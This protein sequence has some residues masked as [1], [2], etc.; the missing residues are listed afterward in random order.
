MPTLV[1]GFLSLS[2]VCAVA[3]S[4]CQTL[5]VEKVDETLTIFWK[6]KTVVPKEGRLIFEGGVKA[7]YGPTVLFADR[8]EIATNKTEK[9]GL[10]Q[11]NVRIEDPDAEAKMDSFSFDWG[12]QI[13]N[14]SNVTFSTAGLFLN[15][16]RAEITAVEWVFTGVKAS[17]D[18]SAHPVFS[19]KS[20]R[21]TYRPGHSGTA[22]RAS[23]S[24]FGKDWVTLPSY[25]FGQKEEG[26]I[27]RFPSI[28]ANKGL[29]VSWQTTVPLDDR[30][31]FRGSIKAKS[32]EGPG[33]TLEAARSL[34]PR[35]EPGG[36]ISPLSDLNERF[37]YGYF[38]NVYTKKP[39]DERDQIQAR[40]SA[41]SL[42]MTV[43]RLPV[44]RL[45]DTLLTKPFEITLEQARPFGGIA[46]YSAL[47]FHDIRD[48]SGL[49]ERRV[50]S[51]VAALLPSVELM[52]G[53]R[54]HA[55]LDFSAYSG[56][57]NTFGWGQS[58]LGLIFSPSEKFSLGASMVR[59]SEFGRPTYASDRLFSR[60]GYHF[61]M[62]AD[63]GVVSLCALSKY[64][65][66]LKKWFDNELQATLRA[67]SVN[68]FISYRQFPRSFAFGVHLQ[69]EEV[70]KRISNRINGKKGGKKL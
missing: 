35:N 28:S 8:L 23:L 22:K 36:I 40:R 29:G 15:A 12:K 19:L 9:H 37:S 6:T 44:G 46:F 70:F 16:E 50:G 61:R 11:G 54:T 69:A 66:G 32:G 42:G 64:D 10:A 56:D 59:G 14:A 1:R 5:Q 51:N 25:S 31:R 17:P 30:S 52:P 67:G 45:D 43:N 55:R 34:L 13:G 63:L 65:S 4:F 57:R 58:Q 2:M 53:L 47:R 3:V 24:V 60:Y 38:D 20:P 49:S 21:V 33:I 41:I 18:A 7:T 48:E 62:D 39:I 27:L 26:G 68:P